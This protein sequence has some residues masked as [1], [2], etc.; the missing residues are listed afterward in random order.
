ME[1]VILQG[2]TSKIVIVEGPRAVGKSTFARHL[3]E[4]GFFASYST[5]SDPTT[6]LAAEQDPTGWLQSLR[7]PAIID[8]AQ[9]LSELPLAL[10]EFVDTQLQPGNQFLLTGSASLGRSGLGGADPLARR[11]RRYEMRPLTLAE[12][13]GWAPYTPSLVDQLFDGEPNA[14]TY[15]VSN[16]SRLTGLLQRGGF[17]S[18]AFSSDSLNKAALSAQIRSDIDSVLGDHV[19][20][21]ERFDAYR[22]R[23]I[24]D[25]LVR[26]PGGMLNVTELGKQ[27]GLDRRT[28]D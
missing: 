16:G 4:L 10:K 1:K 19:L 7:R 17:P 28:V 27:I 13:N 6:R 8:E 21:D 24:L 5:L 26:V 12:I 18:Y 22:A 3:V 20:P 2:Q 15:A 11:S 9:L 14:G 25:A 23:S